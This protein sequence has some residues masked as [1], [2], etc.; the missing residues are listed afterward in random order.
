MS[1]Y[2]PPIPPQPSSMGHGVRIGVGIV[3]GIFVVVLLSMG[4]CVACGGLMFGLAGREAAR[5]SASQSADPATLARVGQ[6][7]E[8]SGIA[9]TVENTGKSKSLGRFD[10]ADQ[11]NIYLV[12]DVLLETTDR[13]ETSYNP[14][15]FKVKDSDGIEY[16]THLTGSQGTLSSGT[17]Y[18]GDKVRG[19]VVFKVRERAQGFVLTYAPIVLLG[20]YD[21]IRVSLD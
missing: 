18:R 8:R 9:L 16:S 11:N 15:Y 10:T 3:I 20:G 21:P 17:L 5:Q 19:K 12:V 2:R 4:A 1:E 6:R 14:F 13:N 7:V